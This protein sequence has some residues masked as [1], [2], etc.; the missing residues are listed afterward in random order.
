MSISK[1]ALFIAGSLVLSQ[2][3]AAETVSY[4]LRID[5]ADLSRYR[6]EMRISGA[7]E[8]FR[9]A[10]A[11]HP[12]Y[13][14]RFWRFVRDLEVSD[15]ASI[16]REDSALWRIRAPDGKAT[17]R[18]TIALPRPEGSWRGAWIPFLG[19]KGGLV[20]GIDSFMY[21]P[22]AEV[23]DIS[24]TIE[25]P[26]RWTIATALPSSGGAR[27]TA[28]DQTTLLDSPILIGDLSV[29]RFAAGGAPHR[30]AYLRA[31]TSTPFDTLAFADGIERYAREV[32]N[33]FGGRAPYRDFTFLFTDA[34]YG[35]L[36]HSNSVTLGAPSDRLAVDAGSALEDIAHEFF[37]SW[38]LMRI[39]PVER[40]RL[41]Y[42][43]NGQTTGLWWAEG[44]TIFYGDLLLRRAGLPVSDST[45]VR[46]LEGLLERY[47][48]YTGNTKL[49]PE[50]VSMAEYGAEP[51]ALGDYS[52]ASTHLQGELL[53]S[54]LDLVIR[55]K[56]GGKRSIDDLLRLMFAR[57]SAPK[58]YTG[59]DIENAAA[60]ICG[61]DMR[62]FFDSHV[63][64]ATPL[65]FN[66]FLDAI[67]M[68]MAVEWKPA[69]DDS[70]RVQADYR[71]WAQP[72]PGGAFLHLVV[73]D[74]G[75]VWGRAGL[76]SGDRLVRINGT[77][78]TKS[79]E[80]RRQFRALRIG[81]SVDV[82]VDR[83]GA[84]HTTRVVVAGYDRPIV[85][86]T[87]RADATPAQLSL[88]TKWLAG[89]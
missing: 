41:D 1:R 58:G 9:V 23:R 4:T 80:F 60:E 77:R 22:D 54:A 79:D 10:M 69:V 51:F 30:I 68:Q 86:I 13:N 3:A 73:M 70:G 2:A 42:R 52:S 61:C 57:H 43:T 12:E 44:L 15:G 25:A 88:R 6:V 31:P 47:L 67:G 89:Q 7:P 85:R 34:A 49:S 82:V 63:R 5:S 78:M 87:S 39:R 75:S 24:V 8:S 65:D 21:L 72:E 19:S 59:K 48:F 53:G 38:N 55:Q 45:R 71:M 36:E 16:L 27:F 37:H 84:Q 62:S 28:A 50:R 74:P 66:K 76:H 33:L 29:W 32:M 20:G 56:T 18:Y 14:E 11:A 46:H 26:R 35:G 64:A 83:G 40:G 81:D 17:I